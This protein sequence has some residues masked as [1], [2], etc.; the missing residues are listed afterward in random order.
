MYY[1]DT[2]PNEQ[3]GGI[4]TTD[5]FTVN[6]DARDRFF[7]VDNFYD[8]PEEFRDF[9]VSQ[10]YFD[11]EGFEGLRTRKQFFIDGVKEK[12]ESIISRKIIKWKEYAMN[13]RFQS[14]KA[15]FRSVWHCDSQQWAAAI[16]LNPDAPYE[17][18]TCVYAHK[19]TRG[20]DSQEGKNIFNQK[21]FVDSTPYEL[22]DQVG[23]VFNRLVIWDAKLLHAAPVYFGWDINSSRLS[24]VFFFDTEENE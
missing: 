16:Y 20:R 10:W 19:E 14:H 12:F 22:V 11:D 8:N 2:N 18:G 6:K 24:Q 4:V 13:A 7:V 23:N 1:K 5:R 21:T 17:A 9:A 15:D 3:E